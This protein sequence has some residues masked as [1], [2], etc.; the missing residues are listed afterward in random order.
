MRHL[1]T[2]LVLTS[3]VVAPLQAFALEGIGPR[4]T[5]TGTVEEIRLTEKQK[6]DR[7][8]G[9]VVIT[10][11]NGQKVTIVLNEHTS[12]ISEGRISRKE[13]TPIDI[14][15]GALIRA[16]GWRVG[17]DAITASLFILENAQVN[18]VLAVSGTLL[19]IDLPSNTITVL[20]NDGKKQQY[21]VATNTEV[22]VSYSLRGIDSLSFL[23]KKVLLTLNPQQPKSVRIIRITGEKEILKQTQGTSSLKLR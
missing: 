10:A 21:T 20:T 22:Y 16:R 7:I 12:I 13:L 11:L 23:G 9:E 8:G 15:V 17:E 19:S 18:P 6:F 5:V 2:L 1:I 4:I 3:F 14:P